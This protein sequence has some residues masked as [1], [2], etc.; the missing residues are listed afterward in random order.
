LNIPALAFAYFDPK[1]GAYRTLNARGFNVRVGGNEDAQF[2]QIAG[3]SKTEISLL[4]QDIRF[5]A[6]NIQTWHRI[7][8]TVLNEVWFWLLNGLSLA[9]AVGAIGVRWWTDKLE[10]NLAFAR[11]RK[12]WSKAQN[13]LRTL[14]DI[15]E[16]AVTMEFYSLLNQILIGYIADRLGLSAS[17]GPKEIEQALQSKKVPP[18]LIVS[19]VNLLTRLDEIR[20]LPGMTISEKPAELL[21]AGRDILINLGRVI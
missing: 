21:T 9:I 17:L 2:G 20:F 10:T 8:R 15:P 6:R 13:R 11:R 4:G 14:S 12:A 19:V 18:D 5:I 3:L 7:G 1:A 16:S